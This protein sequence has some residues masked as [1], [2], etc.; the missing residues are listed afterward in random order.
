MSIAESDTF[1]PY[2]APLVGRE[3]VDPFQRDDALIR[4]QFIDCEGNIRSIASLLILGG[5]ILA[6]V[7]GFFSVDFVARGDSADVA[8]AALFGVIALLGAAQMIVGIRLQSFRP[9]ARIGGIVCCVLWMFFIP[10]GTIIGG[11][12]LWYLVRPA[13]KYV[14]APEYREVIRKTPHIR[15]QTSAVSWVFFIIMLLSLLTLIVIPML[16]L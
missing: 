16:Q 6:F 11:A 5:L 3:T 14:F 15:F 8:L 10:I 7:F 12:C 2:A 1:N 4:K 13:A 9:R